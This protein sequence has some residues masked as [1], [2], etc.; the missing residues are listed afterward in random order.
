MDG[1]VED[2]VDDMNDGSNNGADGNTSAVACLSLL[3]GF[4]LE[5]GSEPVVGLPVRACALIAYLALNQGR[6]ATRERIAELIW[7]DRAGEQSR[8]SLRQLLHGLNRKLADGSPLVVDR[9]GSLSIGF[10]PLSCDAVQLRQ[11][12]GI[13]AVEALL[14]AYESY[15]GPLLEGLP[16]ISQAFD[17][18]LI[19]T[20]TE[21][22]DQALAIGARLVEAS[23]TAG[24]QDTAVAIDPL[25]EDN[26]R[27][28]MSAYVAA[29][30]R[31]DALRQYMHVSELL[32]REL[33]VGPAP[34]T[35]ELVSRLRNS[36][37][38]APTQPDPIVSREDPPRIAV[39]PFDQFGDEHFPSHLAGGMV[40]DIIAQ[41]SGLRELSVISHG[42]TM[43]LHGPEGLA[44]VVEKLGVRY[45]VR[46]AIRQAQDD[47]RL[48]TELV[49]ADTGSVVGTNISTLSKSF[50]FADQDRVVAHTVNSLAPRVQDLELIRIRGKRPTS[51]SSYE[52]ILLAREYMTSVDR[53]NFEKAKLLIDDVIAEEPTYA[54]AYALAADWYGL[55]VAEGHATDRTSDI[56]TV[57]KLAKTALQYDSMNVR[58]LVFYGHRRSLFH[59]DYTMAKSLF[60][61]ALDASPNSTEA[62]RW[63]SMTY[64]FVGEA[65]EAI[66]RAELALEL[67]PRDRDAHS[68]YL[69]L[70]AAY[71]TAGDYDTAAGHGLRA[72]ATVPNLPSTGG[73]AAASLAAA[74]RLK[75]AEEVA[76]ETM[77]ALPHRRVRNIV[78]WH[79]FAD[80]ARRRTYGEHLLAA[81][82]PE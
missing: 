34:E 71:Y 15:K 64:S 55:L 30:R 80:E 4:T 25:R 8:S 44:S 60:Q 76:R 74:G 56:E 17:D 70:C 22:E 45:L 38:D 33:G 82:F 27:R 59:R 57:E 31:S 72:M 26:H 50:S 18:W 53:S 49:A 79:P 42:S 21:L 9:D 69:A 54:E 52:K 6:P 48:T 2:H 47:V 24:D 13:S 66:G 78:E 67:S 46:G 39:L 68:F 75:E 58:A 14:S 10:S 3:G 7:P 12:N 16:P 63:S 23:M 5:I 35:E 61:R 32:R 62:L 1:I 29:G 41:L 43:D 81:G 20:R 73:W 77:A 40:A 65:E 28:L 37:K 51:M 36:S 19:A 11:C